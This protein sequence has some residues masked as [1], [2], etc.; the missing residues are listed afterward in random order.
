MIVGGGA[1]VLVGPGVNVF[2]GVNVGLGVFD[3][4]GVFD[5]KGLGSWKMV[6][7]P[8]PPYQVPSPP[9]P[10]L[11]GVPQPIWNQL[12]FRSDG[13]MPQAVSGGEPVTPNLIHRFVALFGGK[14]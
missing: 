6:I 13:T 11:G 10:P 9:L 3:G 1:G 2:D 8:S 14:L 7:R 12:P 5:G 4:P